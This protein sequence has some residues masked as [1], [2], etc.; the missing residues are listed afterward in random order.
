[1][2]FRHH[3]VVMRHPLIYGMLLILAGVVPLMIW[4]L[5]NIAVMI[6]LGSLLL[7]ILYWFYTWIGWYYSV[8]ILTDR[9]LIDI[10]QKG[11]FN[12]K[13]SE[14]GLDRIQSL[15]YHIK[16]IQAALFRFGTITV[17]TYVGEWVMEQV[18]HPVEVH[19]ALMSATREIDG[20]GSTPNGD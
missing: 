9:R 6:S 3:P 19:S 16:G 5:S 12:R 15:N 1:M 18:E 7:A 10:E 11:L 20:S 14:V 8:F 13:V 17:Q 2:V 4:P